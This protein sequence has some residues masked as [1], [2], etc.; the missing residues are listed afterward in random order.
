[1]KRIAGSTFLLLVLACAAIA[2]PAR[3]P[4]PDRAATE[5]ELRELD[6]QWAAV[7]ARGDVAL[8]DRLTAD[9]VI[10]THAS[11]NLV[12][13]ADE[14]KYI[15]TSPERIAAITTDDVAIRLYGDTAVILGRVT[16]KMKKGSENRFRYTTVWKQTDRWRLIAEQHTKIEPVKPAGPSAAGPAGP[17]AG[18][19]RQA[20]AGRKSPEQVVRDYAQACNDFDLA[21]FVALHSPTVRKF[22]RAD[23]SGALQPGR[24]PGEF[25][26]TTSGRDEV[27]RK[28][29]QLFARTP[30]T[31]R[32]EIVGMFALGDLVVSRDRVTGFADGHVSD[33]I[34]LYQVKDGLIHAIWY[35]ERTIH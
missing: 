10:A 8:F 17:A 18:P 30:R 25:V 22:K 34:T 23:E 5:R 21:R 13:K 27:K 20:G 28:Y 24:P 12:A 33:E 7:A 16:V 29:E 11:G 26:L 31:V 15:A 1:M 19:A 3:K 6:R 9:D 14:K 35:L 32:V 4:A 2:G